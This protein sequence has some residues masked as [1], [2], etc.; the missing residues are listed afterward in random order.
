MLIEAAEFGYNVF[1]RCP[2]PYAISYLYS[3]HSRARWSRQLHHGVVHWLPVTR[4]LG[5]LGLLDLLGTSPSPSSCLAGSGTVAEEAV[6]VGDVV[7][8]YTNQQEY[9]LLGD[10][11]YMCRDG[12]KVCCRDS[13]FAASAK[14]WI[15]R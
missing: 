14:I 8:E 1:H 3:R 12:M 10:V 5:A 4:M 9:K 15:E 11:V 13:F 6:V 2:L 7:T